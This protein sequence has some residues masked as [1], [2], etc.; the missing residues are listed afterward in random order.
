M[1]LSKSNITIQTFCPSVRPPSSSSSLFY[2]ENG[3][4]YRLR[5]FTEILEFFEKFATNIIQ[6]ALFTQ[7][8][9]FKLIKN[10]LMLPFSY[11]FY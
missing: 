5:V 7:C 3:E 1:L 4:S 8:N 2:L 10:P 9:A 6:P 11:F